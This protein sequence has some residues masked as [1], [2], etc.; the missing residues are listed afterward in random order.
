[1][2]KR[3]RFRHSAGSGPDA[4]S[5]AGHKAAELC[6]D[7]ALELQDPL[8]KTVDQLDDVRVLSAHAHAFNQQAQPKHSKHGSIDR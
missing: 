8:L 3:S 1:M 6:E 2:L 7:R 4:L 5:V